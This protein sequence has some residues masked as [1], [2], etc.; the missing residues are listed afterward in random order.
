MIKSL[1]FR[2]RLVHYVGIVLLIIN[3]TFFTD[4]I[5]GQVIQYVIAVVILIHDLDEKS[6][7]VDMT[8]SL[9]EQLDRLEHGNEVV[10]KNDFNSELSEAAKHVNRFQEIFLK[11]QRN[12]ENAAEIEKV[13]HQIDSDYQHVTQNIRNERDMIGHIV[14]IGNELESLLSEGLS[15][16]SKSKENIQEVSNELIKIRD[17]ISE[18]VKELHEASMS[19]NILADDL[20]RVSSD[21][22]EVK[23]VI[24]VI[25]DIAEQTN[26]LALNAA[27]EAA[28]AG[29]HG[30]G[31]AVVADE[32][33]KLAERTQKSLTEINATINVVSQSISDTSDQMNKSSS[34]I[35][36]L[37]M[38]SK[39]ASSS[40]DEISEVIMQAVH[41]AE[42]TVQGYT[43]NASK[44]KDII[45][46]V[47][48]VDKLSVNTHESVEV[49][50]DGVNKLESII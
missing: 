31:F 50:K 37:S 47:S 33:R 25:E 3:G 23:E 39:E 1:F 48:E 28:R 35:E 26:L 16:A 44:T 22:K 46:K 21:T 5:I 6:N 30:R 40:V 12:D 49:I 29:E 36:S 10:L 2:M 42:E 7:G 41:V 43:T 45:S 27:I 14:G 20:N 38:V 8:K 4:N 19:Q 13:I 32:V 9:I 18:I 24:N 34:N 17:E 11:A 15:E